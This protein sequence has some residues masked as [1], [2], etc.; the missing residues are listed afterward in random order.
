VNVRRVVDVVSPVA[1]LV[2]ARR[3]ALGKVSVGEERMFRFINK[4]RPQLHG[5]AWVVM[6]AGSLAAVPVAA[7]VALPK[8]R[9]AALALAIDGTAVWA[10]CK[11]VKRVVKRGRPA[12]C[13]DGVVICGDAQS[14]G[15]FPSGHTAVATTLTVI[16]AR[17]LPTTAA[18]LA[19]AVPL[20]V[21]AGRQ[22]VGAHL[23]LDV[24]GGA[25]LGITAGNLANFALDVI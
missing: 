22:F 14:G 17:L 7:A 6:Q 20:L 21:G 11:L 19:W 8:D 18:R 10:M 16:G 1:F 15:G 13:L 25:A 12:D 4:H 9:A 5:P 24:A 2:L 23:P 3:A